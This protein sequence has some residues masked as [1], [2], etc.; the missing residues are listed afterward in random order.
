MQVL[1]RSASVLA[2]CPVVRSSWFPYTAV[3]VVTKATRTNETFEPTQTMSGHPS[4]RS[5]GFLARCSLIQS[6]AREST[7]ILRSQ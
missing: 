6:P 3:A 2:Q 1:E 7:S 5:I 4:P